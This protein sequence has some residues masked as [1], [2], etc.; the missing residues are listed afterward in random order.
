MPHAFA[1]RD[2]I[3]I[4]REVRANW[5]STTVDRGDAYL[6]RLWYD[7]QLEDGRRAVVYFDRKARSKRRWWLY[8]LA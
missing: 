4:V 2:E 8:T 6:A 1:W 5:R 7:L 3:L